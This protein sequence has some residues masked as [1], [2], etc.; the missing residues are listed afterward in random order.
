MITGAV[1]VLEG[2]LR[3]GPVHFDHGDTVPHDYTQA[4]DIA[5]VAAGQSAEIVR[6]FIPG[7]DISIRPKLN[8]YDRLEIPMRGLLAMDSV[9]GQ[10]GYRVRYPNLRDGVAQH[11]RR[12]GE[13]F[14][15]QGVAPAPTKGIQP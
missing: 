9:A 7:A 3:G 14:S 13:F 6:E 12:H 4:E 8:D 1:N 5:G 11:I 10:P 2:A 15:R